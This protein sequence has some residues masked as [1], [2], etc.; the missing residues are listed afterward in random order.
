MTAKSAAKSF[1]KERHEKQPRIVGNPAYESAQE[2][3]I[4]YMTFCKALARM[5][6]RAYRRPEAHVTPYLQ[7]CQ[8][9]TP[10]RLL[11]NVDP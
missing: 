11:G 1:H 2:F 10:E 3:M 8:S 6:A 7:G 4:S 5:S 9:E